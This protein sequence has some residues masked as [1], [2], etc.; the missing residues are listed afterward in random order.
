MGE[1]VGM[2]VPDRSGYAYGICTKDT[3]L[4]RPLLNCDKPRGDADGSGGGGGG[5]GGGEGEGTSFFCV[6][7]QNRHGAMIGFTLQ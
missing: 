7:L 2:S 6:F 1:S 4:A 3:S 5:G